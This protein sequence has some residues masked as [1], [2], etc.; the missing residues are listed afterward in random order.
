MALVLLLVGAFFIVKH[1][2]SPDR[3]GE[4]IAKAAKSEDIKTLSKFVTTNGRKLSDDELRAYIKLLKT[5]GNL[6]NN[7]NELQK[8]IKE[9]NHTNKKEISVHDLSGDLI[10]SV[11]EEGKRYLLFNK[12]TYEIPQQ[13]FKI[14]GSDNALL[15]YTLD[16][17]KREVQL[18]KQEDVYL[19][20]FTIGDY[21][22]SASKK[23][24]E[25]VHKGKLDLEM[26]HQTPVATEKFKERWFTIAHTSGALFI[27][28][29]DTDIYVNDKKVGNYAD[30]LRVYS[31][32]TREE[33]V[34]IYAI[35]KMD[36]KKTFK[37]NVVSLNDEFKHANIDGIIDISLN[38][39][40]KEIGDYEAKKADEM[41][42]N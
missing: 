12:Y 5:E 35:G 15:T 26:M 42:N 41:S 29:K 7:G 33:N 27:E 4:Q 10:L 3:E 37:S 2:L 34:K 31:P 36:N 18:K 20:K 14:K 6:D 38:F 39:D 1:Q 8:A 28:N 11:K 32:Y 13:D 22:L 24:G 30:S 25:R 16:G 40:E 21:S 17:K 9:A 23:I 19:G